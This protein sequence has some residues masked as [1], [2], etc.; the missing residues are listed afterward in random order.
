M[1]HSDNKPSF[2]PEHKWP[3]K[4]QRDDT[5]SFIRNAQANSDSIPPSRSSEDNIPVLAMPSSIRTWRKIRWPLLVGIVLGIMV[6]IGLLTNNR[7][8]DRSV[9]HQIADA[10]Q[11]ES[12]AE[13]KELYNVN[14]A[15]F[16][17]AKRYPSRLNTQAAY[18]WNCI[19]LA[20]MF[21]N[22]KQHL[23]NAELALE[24][25]KA[26]NSTASLYAKAGAKYI[27]GDTDTALQ[28]VAKGLQSAPSE[29]RL[30]LV[31]AWALKSQGNDDEAM[32]VLETLRKNSSTYLPA[33]Y[34]ALDFALTDDNLKKSSRY[35]R[36]LLFISPG[37]LFATLAGIG[38]LLPAWNAPG[39]STKVMASIKTQIDTLTTQIDNAPPR[40]KSYGNYLIGRVSFL[41]GDLKQSI[42][43]F[44]SLPRGGKNKDVGAWHALA[45]KKLKGSMAALKVLSKASDNPTP[46]ELALKAECL[47]DYHHTTKAKAAISALNAVAPKQENL[48]FLK[49]I[50]A[51]RM[52]NL[53][54]AKELLPTE[55]TKQHTWLALEMYDLLRRFGD[56]DGISTL[57]SR[58]SKDLEQCATAINKWHKSKTET[59]EEIFA[60]DDP[61]VLELK[62]MLLRGHI[63]P[64]QQKETAERALA[65][66]KEEL[67]VKVERALS[68]WLVDGRAAA[69]TALQEVRNQEP[70][71]A[72][73]LWT[74]ANGYLNMGLNDEV[75]SLL[76]DLDDAESTALKIEAYQH[77]QKNADA[78]A[79]LSDATQDS[80][81]NSHP[82]I[83][84]LAISQ[85][86]KAQNFEDVLTM[87]DA[88]LPKAGIWSAEIA[89]LKA[90]AQKATGDRAGADRGLL[91]L[92][93]TVQKSAGLAE[94]W[95]A[96]MAV[97]RMNLKRGGNF[98]YKAVGLILEMF[99]SK[100]NDPEL[101]Y[102]YAAANIQQG[103]DKGAL[104]YLRAANTLDPSFKP[105]IKQLNLMGKLSQEDR[106]L[107]SIILPDDKF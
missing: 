83:A 106:K 53:P 41:S 57:T 24:R 82:A 98:I 42:E 62:T 18:A 49:W 28:I 31:K 79:L 50:L 9:N 1:D 33:L 103:N 66:G 32:N 55:L 104:K 22:K 93:R 14:A 90:H 16:V 74:M 8:V 52:G 81:K 25:I 95:Q 48:S 26:D 67:R 30:Q 5:P 107:L 101:S 71:G 44:D 84:Y 4:Q 20:E 60:S 100:V 3:Q 36:D 23:S 27:M 64:S 86:L 105:V 88:I 72:L 21:G 17:L 89:E 96:K 87:S 46:P 59:A 38:I 63:P 91:S 37:N 70:D 99:S 2:S 19:L 97:I 102:S 29:P 76:K 75:L 13:I 54:G 85:S 68:L 80:T 6:A 47:L 56:K 40:I 78:D 69:A 39:P 92:A 7:L 10:S 34:F 65:A 12:L 77:S 45:V 11:T 51:I 94:S 35:K 73:L 61:C 58:M 43:K 15:L